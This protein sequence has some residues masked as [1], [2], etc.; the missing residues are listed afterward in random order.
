MEGG[1]TDY[2]A[3]RN[4]YAIAPRGVGVRYSERNGMITGT[5]GAVVMIF[6]RAV[7]SSGNVK[8]VNT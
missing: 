4:K 8:S 1:A 3:F 2:S 6:A 5:L 7:G